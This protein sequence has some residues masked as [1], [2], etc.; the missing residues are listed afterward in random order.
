MN[1]VV[2]APAALVDV[3]RADLS[4]PHPFAHERVGFIKARCMWL[5][6]GM[7]GLLA[8]GYSPVDDNDYEP[9]PGVGAQIGSDAIRKALQAAYRPQQALLHVHTHGGCGTPEFSGIDRRSAAEFVPSFF[10][11][12]P[13]VPHGILVLSNDAATGL[14]WLAENGPPISICGFRRVGAPYGKQWSAK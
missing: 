5:E 6:Q 11:T 2:K 9:A 14:L 4:R 7:L 13:R 3:V 12:L 10:T 1:I 8:C